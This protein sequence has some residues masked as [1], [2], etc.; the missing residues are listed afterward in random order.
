MA[1]ELQEVQIEVKPLRPGERI[2]PYLIVRRV[3][4]GIGGMAV[5]YEAKLH[6][7][8]ESV[9]VKVAHTGLASF[10]KDEGAFTTARGLNHPHIITLLPTPLGPGSSD[11][12]VRDPKSGAWYFAMEYM[13]GGSLRDWMH[14]RKRL[15]LSNAVEVMRQIGSALDAAHRADIVHLDVK[16]SNIL[17]RER[18]ERAKQLH[19]VLTDFGIAR[20]R[21]QVGGDQGTLTVEYASPEQAMLVQGAMADVGPAS[22]LYSLAAIFYEMVSG[23]LPFHAEG[24]L[25]TLHDIV[26]EP[27]PTPIPHAPPQLEPILIRAL[28]KDPADR[29]PTAQAMIADLQ[30]LP[31]VV[32][33]PK[34]EGRGLHPA[35][36][37]VMGLVVGAILGFGGGFY[38]RGIVPSSP[39][40]TL[41]VAPT[42]PPMLTIPVPVETPSP[43]ATQAEE[44]ATPTP[45]AT[46]TRR[47]ATDTPPPRP[48][49]T[50][51]PVPPSPP[52]TERP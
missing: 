52:P 2:G 26:Y 13:A 31:P 46:S 49:P 29:Y 4:G 7:R 34:A 48:W 51:T 20:P 8:R 47:P 14:R 38:V 6:G 11:Y 40:P 37:G 33:S 1:D 28:A 44:A 36:A 18:P 19:A 12:I 42:Q 21:G 22:D 3:P 27:I 9:A 43:T 24:D 50:A 45:F 30:S 16:P 23:K 41:V 17:F 39:T 15:A 10:L 35:L 5:V 32:L 25:A